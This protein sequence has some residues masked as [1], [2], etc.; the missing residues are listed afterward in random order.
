MF[1]IQGSLLKINSACVKLFVP[2]LSS[3]QVH[4][5]DKGKLYL[6]KKQTGL[7][8]I[9][10]IIPG[11]GSAIFPKNIHFATWQLILFLLFLMCYQ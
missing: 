5:A 11:P 8:K 10:Y 6:I 9:D 4:N 1:N 2:K 7:D 3:L